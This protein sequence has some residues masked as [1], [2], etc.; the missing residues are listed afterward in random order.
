MFMDFRVPQNVGNFLASLEML[1]PEEGPCSIETVSS[2]VRSVTYN[3]VNRIYFG[4]QY[5]YA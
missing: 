4:K 2:S 1:A 5:I 3:F